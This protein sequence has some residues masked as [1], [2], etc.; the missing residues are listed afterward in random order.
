MYNVNVYV[1]VSSLSNSNENMLSKWQSKEKLSSCCVT[2][3]QI[4]CVVHS[5]YAL[6]TNHHLTAI[7]FFHYQH[8]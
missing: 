8:P 7:K 4:K 3:L 5:N 1:H 6:L 2:K